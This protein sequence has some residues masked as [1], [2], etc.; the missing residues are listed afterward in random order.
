M[1]YVKADINNDN[2]QQYGEDLFEVT[3]CKLQYNCNLQTCFDPCCAEAE[4]EVTVA[5]AKERC[6]KDLTMKLVNVCKKN[7]D[8]TRQRN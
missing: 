6:I 2:F 1:M 4:I 8:V 3:T 5:D 7:W